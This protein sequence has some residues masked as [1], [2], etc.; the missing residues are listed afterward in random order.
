MAAPKSVP[1]GLVASATAIMKATYNQTTGT[2]YIGK[3]VLK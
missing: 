3:F 2:I 1:I